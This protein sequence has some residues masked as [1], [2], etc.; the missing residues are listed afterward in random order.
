MCN[1]CI[2]CNKNVLKITIYHP[3]YTFPN[4]NEI[5]LTKLWSKKI[6]IICIQISTDKSM[7][8]IL[9]NQLAY[10][11]QLYKWHIKSYTIEDRNLLIICFFF[12]SCLLSHAAVKLYLHIFVVF[13]CRQVFFCDLIKNQGHPKGADLSA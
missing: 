12:L 2:M 6:I 7:K 13:R 3:F 1:T 11:R 8:K 4:P 10:L 5:K 9:K